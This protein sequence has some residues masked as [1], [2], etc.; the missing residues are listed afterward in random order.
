VHTALYMSPHPTSPH[1]WDRET[2]HLLKPFHDVDYSFF[3]IIQ[4]YEAGLGLSLADFPQ[5]GDT[6]W[7]RNLGCWHTDCLN[8]PMQIPWFIAQ[9]YLGLRIESD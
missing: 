4:S 2:I 1:G 6:I 5:V 8:L 7:G 3:A 9:S